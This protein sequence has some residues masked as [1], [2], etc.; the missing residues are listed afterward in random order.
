MNAVTPEAL[1]RA[2]DLPLSTLLESAA[3]PPPLEALLSFVAEQEAMETLGDLLESEEAWRYVKKRTSK[4]HQETLLQVVQD[5]LKRSPPTAPEDTLPSTYAGL[6]AWAIANG[7]PEAPLTPASVLRPLLGPAPIELLDSCHRGTQVAQF[8][9]ERP[10]HQYGYY[11]G[12]HFSR[13]LR[14]VAT[15]WLLAEA[16]VAKALAKAE[17]EEEGSTVT[18]LCPA[19]AGLSPLR[20]RLIALRAALRDRVHPSSKSVWKEGALAISDEPFAWLYD[21]VRERVHPI[22]GRARVRISLDRWQEKETLFAE[23]DCQVR[24]VCRHL[25]AAVDRI[26]HWM[27]TAPEDDQKQLV[28]GVLLDP[29]WRRTLGVLRSARPQAPAEEGTDRLIWVLTRSHEWSLRPLLQRPGRRA[30]SFVKVRQP[31]LDELALRLLPQA[32]VEDQHAAQL[33]TESEHRL[34]RMTVHAVRA[35]AR[36]GRVFSKD[37]AKPLAFVEAP[38]ELSCVE[39][40][41]GIELQPTV[42]GRPF[43]KEALQR[44]D[45]TGVEVHPVLWIKEDEGLCFIVEAG[46][47]TLRW[48]TVL[49]RRGSAF[50]KDAGAELAE[51]LEAANIPAVLPPSLQG[52]AVEA[53]AQPDVFLSPLDGLCFEVELRVRP[54]RGGLPFPIGEGQLTLRATVEGR[55]VHTTRDAEAER[56]QAR[57]LWTRLELPASEG[58]AFRATAEG[59]DALALLQRLEPMSEQGLAVHWPARRPS[60]TRPAKAKDL[61][62]AVRAGRDWFGLSGTVDIDGEQVALAQ[63]LEAARQKRR[64][65]PLEGHRFVELSEEL[66]GQL[67]PVAP[68]VFEGKHGAEVSLSAAAPLQ[69]LAAEVGS[70]EADD[71]FVSLAQRMRSAASAPVELPGELRAQLRPYQRE[72]FVWLS[73]VA[74]WGAGACLADDMGLGKTLQALALL[75]QRRTQGPAL[76]VAPTSVCFNWEAEAQKFAPCLRV[77][78]YHQVDRAQALAQLQPGDVLVASYGLVARDAEA[79]GAARF[80]TLVLDEAHAVKNAGTQRARA[81]RGLTADFKLALT[82]TPMENHLGELWSLFRVLLPGLFG[83]EEQFKVR[84]WAP[85]EREKDGARQRAL[86]GMLSP[87]MLRR[88]KGEVAR[89]LPPRTEI[90]VPVSLSHAERKLYEQ[91]R[92]AILAQL[93][94]GGAGQDRRFQVLAGLTKLRLLSCHPR[95]HDEGWTG[96]TSK[97]DRLLELVEELRAEG[98]RALI[99]SQFTRHLALVREALQ[100]RGVRLQY[101]DGETPEAERRKRVQAFQAGEG[102]VFLISLK[103]GGMGLNLTGADNVIHLDPWWNPAVEDQATDRAHRIGQTRPVTVYRL[104]TQ[105]TLEESIL[106]LHAEKREL[107]SGVLEGGG[108]AAKLAVED[109]AQLLEASGMV[110]ERDDDAAEVPADSAPSRRRRSSPAELASP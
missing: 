33:L 90:V 18:A 43:P 46:V 52:D 49:A 95:L 38:L 91:A 7:V 98:H 10:A 71:S 4:A 101:L 37:K 44:L 5:L 13:R 8:I 3:L 74:S 106:S 93:S 14:Q 83:S 11:L 92:L 32:Q 16:S 104:V 9:G 89:D 61:R 63:L 60:F 48:L 110:D 20:A 6:L 69:A 23:C 99:F 94:G 72:G 30:G 59:E 47:S 82:G 21:D 28:R 81:M 84:F 27:H 56:T 42:R 79:F 40:A 100:E 54:L 29:P 45:P 66:L 15:Q 87:F 35:L 34:S 53:C 67:A 51:E 17:K 22:P 41:E 2:M 77:I 1:E 96:A 68:L 12:G 109:L 26:L 19:D 86:K 105:G 57:A 24:G 102:E 70:F 75:V 25:L 108:A 73:R 58:E 55:R 88:T 50:P 31:R 80:A 107:V 39:S 85:I 103:A 65:V 78:R 36:S 76:V 64:F 62:L 97:L